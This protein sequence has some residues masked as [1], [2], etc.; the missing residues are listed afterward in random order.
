[1]LNNQHT[2]PDT[3]KSTTFP[4][5]LLMQL[6][7]Q[8]KSFFVVTKKERYLLTVI[9]IKVPEKVLENGRD[10]KR[11]IVFIAAA[12]ALKVFSEFNLGTC[13]NGISTCLHLPP[14]SPVASPG[15][16]THA[17]RNLLGAA[18]THTVLRT[19]GLRGRVP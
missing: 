9:V 14:A 1:M 2:L 11:E 3:R 16:E 6:V 7:Y 10:S 15:Y 4:N 17:V 13:C 19:R 5:D 12:A 18:A 8:L